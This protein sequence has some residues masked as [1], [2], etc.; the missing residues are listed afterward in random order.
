MRCFK[1]QEKGFLK[2]QMSYMCMQSVIKVTYKGIIFKE[3]RV[4]IIVNVVFLIRSWIDTG[5][6]FFV[7]GM[8]K[9]F[10]LTF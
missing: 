4:R 2:I 7:T 10:F 1:N 3:V 6:V 9:R 5:G 8:C